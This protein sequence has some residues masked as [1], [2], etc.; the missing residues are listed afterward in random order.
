MGFGGAPL[1]NMYEAFSDVQARATVE[2]CH[3]AGI[4]Y[5]DTAP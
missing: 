4:R 1:G 3:G 5:F 2:A